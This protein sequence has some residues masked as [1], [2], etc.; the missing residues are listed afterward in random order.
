MTQNKNIIIAN[1]KMNQ[2]FDET[3]IW[4]KSF[5]EKIEN[6]TDLPDIVLCP[7][8]ILID[9]ADELLL[10]SELE[11]LEKKGKDLE[12]LE[13]KEIENLAAKIR[14]I[15]IGA[16]DCHFEE[17]GAF[18]GN[19][20]AKMLVDAGC[21]YVILGHSERRQ[22]H[23]ESDEIVQKKI[24]VALKNKLMP[25]L[26]IGESLDIRKKDDHLNFIEQ[27][28]LAS[29][30]KN[31][32]IENLIIA[33]EPIWAIGSGQTP[34]KEQIAQMADFIKDK[35]EQNKDFSV[36]NLRI[37]YGGSTNKANTEEIMSVDNVSGMLVGGSSLKADEFA[38]MTI[39]AK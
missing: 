28:I 30:P 23:F 39:L 25:I 10:D 27:Q 17:K 29:V 20:S 3:E 21:K 24:L 36:K 18:T 33:Y 15:D 9:Y 26:C 2:S 38:Q 19:I 37:L 7:P 12:N 31:I 4:L 14:K 8:A 13:E 5:S 22:H 16:Q 34:S 11:T 32:Q 6:I 35:I 1:W